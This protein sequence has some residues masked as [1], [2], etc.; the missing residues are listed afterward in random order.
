MIFFITSFI[1]NKLHFHKM[2]PIEFEFTVALIDK[3]GNRHMI[4]NPEK[5]VLWYRKQTAD[6]EEV[7]GIHINDISHVTDDV[8]KISYTM[9]QEDDSED[10]EVLNHMLA[11][12][13][14]DGNYPIV[15]DRRKYLIVGEIH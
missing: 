2:V 13:D 6:I 9:N 8:Y 5:I 4:N 14:D 11:D 10:P 7:Y 3:N 15:I 1:K 12:P